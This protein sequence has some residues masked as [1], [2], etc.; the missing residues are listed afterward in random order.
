MPAKVQDT[1]GPFAAQ[2]QFQ[3]KKQRIN[4]VL[5]NKPGLLRYPVLSCLQVCVA[6]WLHGSS[7]LR[8]EVFFE[9]LLGDPGSAEAGI[10]GVIPYLPPQTVRNAGHEPVQGRRRPAFGLG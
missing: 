8:S 9:C 10:S 2:G 3:A 5:I 6:S 4:A 1:D 7:R